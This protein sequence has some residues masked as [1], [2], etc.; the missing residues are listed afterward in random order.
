MEVRHERLG[1][2]LL[3]DFLIVG[4]AKSATSSLHFYLGQH[5]EIRMPAR[6]ESWFFSFVDNPPHYRSPADLEDV[7]S[8]LEDYLALFDG[9]HPQQRLGDASPSYLYTYCETIRNIRAVYPPEYV[10]RLRIIISL[11]DPVIRAWSQYRTFAR[12]VHEPLTFE[13]AIEPSTIARRL[14]DDWNIFYDYIGFGR[15]YQQVK[16]YL[17][18][19]GEERV[20]VVLYEDIEADSIAVCQSIARFIGVAPDFVPDVS[21]RFNSV[22]GEPM[23]KWIARALKSRNPVKRTLAACLPKE[24]REKLLLALGARFLK[25]RALSQSTRLSLKR[26]YADDITRLEGLINRD[27]SRWK[28]GVPCGNNDPQ[29]S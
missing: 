22:S 24:L 21:E 14:S 26:V 17:E 9:V 8:R 7:V 18:A 27:L 11:R 2:I 6:K 4:A 20:L 12:T 5:P 13:R 29:R 1:D 16:A 23:V 3:P 19:F 25:Q 15:Y 28:N 10:D